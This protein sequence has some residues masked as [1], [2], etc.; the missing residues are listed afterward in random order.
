MSSFTN[1]LT[2]GAMIGVAAGGLILVN[3]RVA[4]ISGILGGAIKGRHG[5]WRWT[6]LA[7]LFAAGLLA[8]AFSFQVGS[9]TGEIPGTVPMLLLAGT[10]VGLGTAI[11]SGCT[12]GHGVCG[13][14]NLSPRSL[15]ATIVFMAVAAATVF[16]VRHLGV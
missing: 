4:G 1:A 14:A 8:Q 15:A 9:S 2:G 11:G 12:S 10:F 16:A 7:G 3:G 13:I 5:L 6:F